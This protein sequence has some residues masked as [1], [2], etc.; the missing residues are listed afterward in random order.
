MHIYQRRQPVAD[1]YVIQLDIQIADLRGRLAGLEQAKEIYQSV[2]QS[3]PAGIRAAKG[4]FGSTPERM[5]A[6]AHFSAHARERTAA[7]RPSRLR[8]LV[9]EILAAHPEGLTSRQVND[10]AQG[11]DST[12]NDKTVT[13]M[14]SVAARDGEL[15]RD[16][17]TGR[18]SLPGTEAQADGAGE[19]D[20]DGADD[21]AASD[22]LNEDD[23]GGYE[24]A[25]A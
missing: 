13:S 3:Q 19:A 25:A 1:P 2:S 12:I 6:F 8:T 10:I 20:A 5:G 17:V 15:R 24:R 21:A 18:Y 7:R 23:D 4:A 16:P 22:E 9:W 14:L 11:G